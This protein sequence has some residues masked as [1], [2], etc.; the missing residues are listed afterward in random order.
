MSRNS[1]STVLGCRLIGCGCYEWAIKIS[2]RGNLSWPVR[3]IASWCRHQMETFSALLAI[4]GGIHQSPVNS[5]HIGQWRG[6]LMFTLRICARINGWVNNRE[7]GDLR[8][9]RHHYDVFVM[10]PMCH[11]DV[12]TWKRFPY[13]RFFVD[14]THRWPVGALHNG[15]VM[16]SFNASLLFA[17]TTY[18]TK[19]FVSG[20]SSAME[21][22]WRL[23]SDISTVHLD[24][25]SFK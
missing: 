6:A 13:Y 1:L 20:E 15:P 5:P 16:L 4:C 3:E 19:L 21:L 10:F 2:H 23:C 12:M 17:W 14:W 7:A 11:D 25:H 24:Q 8:R 18:W 9:Y 22:M